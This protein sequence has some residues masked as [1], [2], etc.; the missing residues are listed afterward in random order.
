MYSLVRSQRATAHTLQNVC[1]VNKERSRLAAASSVCD[2][3]KHNGL[4]TMGTLVL[5]NLSSGQIV[6]YSDAR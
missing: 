4:V 2:W 6:R 1:E 3:T 5:V